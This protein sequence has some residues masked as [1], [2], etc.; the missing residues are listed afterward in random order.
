MVTAAPPMYR[1]RGRA[2]GAAV[3]STRMAAPPADLAHVAV[4]TALAWIF[5]WYG[6]GKLF[7]SFN[8]PGIYQ[9]ALFMANTTHLHPAGLFAVLGGVIEFGGGIAVAFALAS[10]LAGHALFGGMVMAIITVTGANG[11]N[12]EKLP[13]GDELN[14]ALAEL[15]L[16]VVLLEARADSASTRLSSGAWWRRGEARR[17][18]SRRP[19]RSFRDWRRLTY[20]SPGSGTYRCWVTRWAP[21]VQPLRK[22]EGIMSPEVAEGP[23]APPSADNVAVRRPTSRVRLRT[24]K[25]RCC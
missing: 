13:A 9:T 2:W 21:G 23:R 10:R 24:P 4:R 1:R 25:S 3:V 14:V 8:G 19:V 5:I 7:G 22:R 20:P 6:A 17:E 12:S 18:R 15:A 16:V 11:I